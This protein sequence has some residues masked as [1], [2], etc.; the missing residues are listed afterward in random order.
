[1]EAASP[2]SPPVAIV[3]A[4]SIGVAFALVFA[5]AGHAVRVFDPDAEART[6]AGTPSATAPRTSPPPAC[7][8]KRPM[9][10]PPA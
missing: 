3:G 6:R 2:S 9:C 7:S 5:R 8:T 10:W 4:G 1:M